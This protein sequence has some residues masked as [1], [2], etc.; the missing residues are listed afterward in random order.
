MGN[1]VPT[2]HHTLTKV[3]TNNALHHF[4]YHPVGSHKPLNIIGY[5]HCSWLS[6]SVLQHNLKAENTKYLKNKV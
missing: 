5:C 6:S 1:N 2:R 4:S 3:N